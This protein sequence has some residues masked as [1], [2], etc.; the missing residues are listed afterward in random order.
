MTIFSIVFAILIFSFLIFTHELGHFTAAKLFG[1]RVNEFSMFMGP[2]LWQKQKGETVYSLRL[3][4]LGGYCAM[5]GEDGDSDDPRSFTAA[6]WW[7]RAI[8]LLAGV[9]MNFI[10]GFA[11]FACF[12]APDEQFILPTVSEIEPGCSL[13]ENGGI[14]PGDTLYALDGERI[15]VNSDFTLLLS[16]SEGNTHDLTVKRDGRLV[17]LPNLLF[18]RREF[19]DADGNT[20]QR[21]GFSFS[22]VDATF[23]ATMK[24][25][26]DNTINTVRMVRLSLKMLTNG[27]ASMKDVTGPVGIVNQMSEVASQSGSVWYAFLN[28]LYFGAFISVNLAVM[29]L[30]PIPALDGGRVVGLILTAMI[31]AVTRKKLDPKYEGYVHAAGMVLL[32]GLMGIVMFKDIWTLIIH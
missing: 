16:L 11:L 28:M 26:W 27:Q 17:E 3:I 20:S 29:N 21:F 8:I 30:L 22:T 9:T 19:T 18:E 7:K 2:L 10:T 15:Y 31:E 6:V 24:Y 1:V 13:V 4:P 32:L 25:A 12:F 23:P 14:Q 5:E